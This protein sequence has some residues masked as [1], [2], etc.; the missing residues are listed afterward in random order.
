M[1]GGVG[2]YT[3]QVVAHWPRAQDFDFVL[4]QPA[5]GFGD[6]VRAITRRRCDLVAQLPKKGGAVLVQYSAYGFDRLGYPR[7]LIDGL[8]DWKQP[9]RGR[10]C[11]MFHEIWGFRPWWN[12]N[13]VVQSLHRRALRR[14][15]SAADAVFTTTASQAEYLA[16]L[17]PSRSVTV[18]PVG[19]NIFPAPSAVFSPRAGTAVVFGMQGTR[20]RALREMADGLRALSRTGRLT[21]VFSMGGGSSREGNAI[22][23]SLLESLQLRDGF[24]QLGSLAPAQISERLLVA[25][26][27]I[28][29][30][31]PLSYTKSG[32]F[33][34][35]A[36][37]GLNILSNHANAA[38]AEPGC[39]LTSPA[40]I[41]D[42]ELPSRSAKLR[43]WYE[44]TASWPHIAGA[45][46]EALA[47]SG[48]AERS[49]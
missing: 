5:A 41:D 9:T 32:T 13:S 34:A 1:R 22:E 7:W 26:F 21:E 45:F 10:L 23:E 17:A 12:K 27:G 35:Y 42:R 47:P 2:D 3:A 11:V 20:I 31:D 30:Q 18:L 46:A 25:E 43:G 49:S 33:M 6:H 44:R 39:L 16:A 28:A 48:S 8:L 38:A 15:I 19:A 29:G 37:H 14:L 40:Q 36:A 4:P 24:E